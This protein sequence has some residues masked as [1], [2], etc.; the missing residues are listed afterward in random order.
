V[1]NIKVEYDGEYPNTCK[2]SLKITVNGDLIYNKEF[3]CEST[4]SVWF[5]D[6]W[7]AHIEDG[8]LLW[9]D[10][11]GFDKEIQKAVNDVLNNCSVCCG[12]CI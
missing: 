3:C 1:R 2:G 6:E 10:A 12:G 11:D 5:D 4:G 8:E 7:N 9:D